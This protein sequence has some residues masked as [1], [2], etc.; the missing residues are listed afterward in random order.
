VLARLIGPRLAESMKQPFVVENKVGASGVIGADFVAKAA[1]NGYTLLVVPNSYTISPAL[2]K[3]MPFDPVAD[4]AGVSRLATTGYSFTVNPKTLPAK[5]VK[6]FI[7]LVKANPGKYTYATP[8]KGTAFHLAMEV[9][10]KELGIDMLH[11]P[12]KDLGSTLASM[13]SGAT[14]AT[15]ATSVLVQGQAKTGA[16]RI[17]AV[18]GTKRSPIVPDVPTFHEAGINFLDDVD[19]YYG[20]LAPAKTPAAI[21]GRLSKEIAAALALPDIAQ[22]LTAA[23][24]S[25]APSTPEQ[26]SAQLRADIR[27]WGQVV[28]D[29]NITAD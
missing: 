23:D 18:T 1:P 2:Y 3:N 8:G 11:V 15:F 14:D 25:A 19:G 26:F 7:A 24:L 20:V 28:K 6:E 16:L 13:V 21:L 5:D 29:A 10:K 17:L 22:K 4:L 12:H 27:R 9:M